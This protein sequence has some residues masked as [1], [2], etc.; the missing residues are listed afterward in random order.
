MEIL[1]KVRQ[2]CDKY[3]WSTAA[4]AAAVPASEE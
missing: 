3:G 1:L 4:A 2:A